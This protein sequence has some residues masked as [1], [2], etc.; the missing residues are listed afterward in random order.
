MIRSQRG[1]RRRIL[2]PDVNGVVREPWSLLTHHLT[3]QGPVRFLLASVCKYFWSLLTPSMSQNLSRL[4]FRSNSHLD[5]HF[6]AKRERYVCFKGTESQHASSYV[7]P[8]VLF[9][10]KPGLTRPMYVFPNV[11]FFV[12]FFLLRFLDELSLLCAGGNR[13]V[14]KG[15]LHWLRYFT[16]VQTRAEFSL[17]E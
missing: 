6:K 7:Y 5:R 9:L 3:A 16:L 12:F 11:F 17:A 14:I 2:T 1:H 4:L 13:S 10:F 8:F 15:R